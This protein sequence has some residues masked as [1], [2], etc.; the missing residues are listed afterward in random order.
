MVSHIVAGR[1]RRL[2]CDGK[3]VALS[4]RNAKCIQ[5]I[6]NKYYLHLKIII[7]NIV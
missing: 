2:T 1:F 5:K 6:S 7:I 4:L 3:A